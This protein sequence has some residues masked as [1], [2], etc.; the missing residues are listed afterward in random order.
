M[1][2]YEQPQSGCCSKYVP[3][4]WSNSPRF[5]ECNFIVCMTR[6]SEG[7]RKAEEEISWNSW[8][9]IFGET[10]WAEDE[11]I[12]YGAVQRNVW[13]YSHESWRHHVWDYESPFSRSTVEVT[14]SLLDVPMMR[15]HNLLLKFHCWDCIIPSWRFNDEISYSPS[16]NFNVIF[17]SASFQALCKRIGFALKPLKAPIFKKLHNVL[18]NFSTSPSAR[19]KNDRWCICHLSLYP[20]PYMPSTNV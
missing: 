5:Q 17:H 4:T 15:L 14:H 19:T 18:A 3:H 16:W 13:S 7:G 9:G 8:C 11:A 10:A 6:S 20:Y 2:V 1:P 12:S